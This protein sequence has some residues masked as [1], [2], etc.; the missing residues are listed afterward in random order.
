LCAARLAPGGLLAAQTESLHFH[1]DTVKKV[2]RAL[3]GLFEYIELVTIPL[4]MYPGN[5][6][7]FTIAST[8]LDP[9]I[10]RNYF[11]P[12]TRIYSREEH[13]WFFLPPAIRA[14]VLGIEQPSAN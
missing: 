7:T 5:W 1:A 9:K 14:K 2:W 11:C 8:S 13:A 3:R 6:W 12:P 4:A 10:V